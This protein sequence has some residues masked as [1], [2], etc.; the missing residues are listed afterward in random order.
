MW[1]FLRNSFLSIV[2]CKDSADPKMFLLVRARLRGDL[3]PWWRKSCLAKW[4][5]L[6]MET[7]KPPSWTTT[8]EPRPISPSG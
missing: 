4:T 8:G 2:E 7:S 3:G 5:K 6:T 1:I